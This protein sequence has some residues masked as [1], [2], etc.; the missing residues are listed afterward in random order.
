MRP[1]GLLAVCAFITWV[2][3]EKARERAAI[4]AEARSRMLVTSIGGLVLANATAFVAA[5][6]SRH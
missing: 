6:T 1:L 5:F 3:F 2:I 4:S